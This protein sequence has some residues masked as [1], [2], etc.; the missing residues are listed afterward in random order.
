MGIIDGTH[1]YTRALEEHRAGYVSRKKRITLN[2]L[3]VV[4][5]DGVITYVKAGR[6]TEII[7]PFTC[8]S[9]IV[10]IIL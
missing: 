3:I 5:L 7:M 4:D 8:N 1:I 6:L 10:Y 9:T 2:N